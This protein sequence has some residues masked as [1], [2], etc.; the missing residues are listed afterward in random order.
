MGSA[1]TYIYIYIYDS[2]RSV[3]DLTYSIMSVNMAYNSR[4]LV[5]W[6]FLCLL[7]VRNQKIEWSIDNSLICVSESIKEI[8]HAILD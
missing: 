6:E 8:V 3:I 7:S 4:F 5:Q 2:D 1:T